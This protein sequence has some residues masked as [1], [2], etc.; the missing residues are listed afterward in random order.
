MKKN[1][2]SHEKE[3]IKK[4]LKYSILDGSFDSVKVGIGESFLAPF[5]IFLKATDTQLGLLSS[6]PRFFGS[7]LQ[8][9]SIRLIHKYK[10]RKRVVMAGVLIQA[11][12]WIPIL[13]SYFF[14]KLRIELLIFFVIAY[15]ISGGIVGPAWNV[16][17]G[18]L[19][20][21]KKRG[22][23]FGKR[24]KIAAIVAFFSL[25]LGGL[26]LNSFADGA[27]RQYLGFA[28]LFFT[29][30]TARLISFMFLSKK[31]EPK[32]NYAEDKDRFS[33][34][35]FLKEKKY[36]NF[37]NFTAYMTAI[38]FSLYVSAPYFVAYMFHDLKFSYLAYTAIVAVETV[39]RFLFMPVWGKYSDRY[40]TKKTM[41]VSGLLMPIVPFLWLVSPKIEWLLAVQVF[42]GFAWAGFELAVFNYL[43]DA[44][45]PEIRA[46]SISYHNV[47]C[48][49]AIFLGS[50]TG[51]TL[52][53]SNSI[54]WT[55]YYIVFL[56]SGILRYFASFVFLGR[57]K[58]T[59]KVK[60]IRYE[61][62]LLRLLTVEVYGIV[63]EIMH[64]D[65]NLKKRFK[66]I[67]KGMTRLS[68]SLIRARF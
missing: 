64:F 26:L 7:L 56:V 28:L 35:Q 67:K 2:N 57:L 37:R 9:F 51:A 25:L 12:I 3:L 40:G 63:N 62:L 31:Y 15:F 1:Q 47:A 68:T 19:V 20:E 55:K 32:I 17:M 22:R 8:L 45:S 39:V 21:E 29:A 24:T 27:E 36:S 53:A 66:K 48:G 65:Y 33:F 42:G 52:V 13:L 60:G 38:N 18:D 6:L 10:S 49:I 30:M 34:F 16:W 11:L 44:T 41:V 59:R 4:S 54:F 46:R 61:K 23:Y 50:M 5:A 14:E 43:F 58:E